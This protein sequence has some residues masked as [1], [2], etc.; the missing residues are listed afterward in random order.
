M[1]SRV[2]FRKVIFRSTILDDLAMEAC[3]EEVD[4]GP[5]FDS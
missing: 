1:G 3:P 4:N 5:R 2:V